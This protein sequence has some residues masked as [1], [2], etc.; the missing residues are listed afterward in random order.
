MLLRSVLFEKQQKVFRESGLGGL[1]IDI[2]NTSCYELGK[3]EA[4]KGT[5]GHKTD[6][7]LD[8][9]KKIVKKVGV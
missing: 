4:Y 8:L 1:L 3:E 9:L 6:I 5:F 2:D 7:K